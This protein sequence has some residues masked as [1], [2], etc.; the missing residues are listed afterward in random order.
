M[1]AYVGGLDYSH[2]MYDMVKSGEEEQVGLT[3]KPFL[4]SLA[5]ENGFA[6]CDMAPKRQ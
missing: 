3:I 1:K 6:L 2:F 5:M 4:Y